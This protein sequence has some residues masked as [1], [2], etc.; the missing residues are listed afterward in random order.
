MDVDSGHLAQVDPPKY[1]II[2][3]SLSNVVDQV[4]ELNTICSVA[5]I[6]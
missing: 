1:C 3:A 2:A 6:F 4:L 5:E